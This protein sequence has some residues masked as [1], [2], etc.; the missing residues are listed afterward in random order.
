VLEAKEVGHPEDVA[1]VFHYSERD[2]AYTPRESARLERVLC[3]HG[4]TGYSARSRQPMYWVVFLGS[5]FV[6][7]NP[8]V[9]VRL[10]ACDLLWSREA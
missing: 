4:L 10:L 2:G 8:V 6:V 7:G 1:S 9:V 3:S 5:G